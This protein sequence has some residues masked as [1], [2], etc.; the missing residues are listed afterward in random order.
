IDDSGILHCLDLKTGAVVYGPTR[1]P[2][3]TYSASPLLADGNIY[4]TNES[5]TTVVFRAG[6]S[7]EI[8]ATNALDDYCL[9]SLAVSD[10]QIFLRTT[11]HLGGIGGGKKGRPGAPPRAIGAG[12]TARAT[13]RGRP[14]HS[15]ATSTG[16]ATA[17]A[18]AD[19]SSPAR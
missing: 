2:P 7:F 8:V 19:T 12:S 14:S 17:A 3:D 4:V 5:G 15:R 11:G 1:L 16:W 13:R 6:A 9:S 18:G 10:G